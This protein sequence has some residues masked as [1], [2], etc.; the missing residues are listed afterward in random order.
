M[1]ENEVSVRDL[2]HY[3]SK[4]KPVE[5]EDTFNELMRDKISTAIENK[6]VELAQNIIAQRQDVEEEPETEE[7]IE[8]EIEQEEED[9]ETA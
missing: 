5:F 2:I 6:K 9:A 7:E 3:S 8:I 1:S 4:Q